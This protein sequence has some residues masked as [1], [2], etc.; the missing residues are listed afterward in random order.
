[1]LSDLAEN[2]VYRLPGCDGETLRKTI[3]EVYREFC[4]ETKCFTAEREIE[5]QPDVADYH[6]PGVFGAMVFEVRSVSIDTRHLRQGIDYVLRSGRCPIVSLHRRHVFVK[7]VNVPLAELDIADRPP[8]MRVVAVEIPLLDSEKMP[9]WFAQQYGDAICSGV[10]AR[11]CSMQG[12][13]WTDNA[14][15]ADERARYENLKSEMRM[16]SETPAGGSFVD[17]SQVL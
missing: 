17:M 11:L 15:A 14:L 7:P 2:L 12:K 4:R 10:L 5:M 3:R 1:M 8:V 13:A 9:R 6:I 16:H